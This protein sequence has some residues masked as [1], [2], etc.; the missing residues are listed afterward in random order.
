LTPRCR[1][2]SCRS[3]TW[4]L[5]VTVRRPMSW[6]RAVPQRMAASPYRLARW[7]NAAAGALQLLFMQILHSD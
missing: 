4:P 1:S 3:V 6:R 5:A 2:N 7:P